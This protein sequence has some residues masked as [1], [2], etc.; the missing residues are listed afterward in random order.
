MRT[1]AEDQVPADRAAF[2]ELYPTAAQK[3]ILQIEKAY[4][5]QGICHIGGLVKLGKG[6]TEE[7]LREALEILMEE[8]PV[9]RLRLVSGTKLI[10][11]EPSVSLKYTEYLNEKAA[12]AWLRRP[13]GDGKAEGPPPLAEFLWNKDP[14]DMLYLWT[15]MHHVLLD[16]CG[17]ALCAQRLWSILTDVRSVKLRG[18]GSPALPE[19]NRPVQPDLRYL[20]MMRHASELSERGER[21]LKEQIPDTDPAEWQLHLP[22]YTDPQA[23]RVRKVLP[24]ELCRKLLAEQAQQNLSPEILI[25]AALSI[26]RTRITG[27]SAFAFGRSMMNRRKKEMDLPGMMANTLP[28]FLSAEDGDSF[29]DICRQLKSRFYSMMRWSDLD[30]EQFRERNGISGPWYDVMLTY[31]PWRLIPHLTEHTSGSRGIAEQKEILPAAMELPLR[32]FIDELEEETFADDGE[33]ALRHSGEKRSEKKTIRFRL[34]YQYQTC[35]Y[36]R[37]EIEA[38][39]LRLMTILEQG[40]LGR[41]AGEICILSE[42]DQK[43]WDRLNDTDEPL[44]G[45][46]VLQKIEEW[47]V[48][49]PDRTA[50]QRCRTAGPDD[51]ADRLTYSQLDHLAARLACAMADRGTGRGHTVGI[52]MEDPLLVPPACLGVWKTGASFLPV[53][54][55]ENAERVQKIQKDCDLFLTDRLFNEMTAGVSAEKTG[56]DAGAD[57]VPAG[58]FSLSDP[59]YQMYTSGSSGEAKL[60]VISH[61]SLACRLDWME[62]KYHC[63]DGVLQKAAVTFD[64]SVWEY[65]LPLMAGGCCYLLSEEEKRDPGIILQCM[66][67]YPVRTVHFVPSMLGIWLRYIQERKADLPRLQ[68]VFSSGEALSA[69]LA[70][71]V[72]RILPGVRLHNLYGPTECTIDVSWHECTK[73]EKE[74]PIGRPVSNTRLQILDAKKRLLPPGICGELSV[75]GALVGMG[76]RHG[77]GGYREEGGT[78]PGTGSEI[79]NRV[80]DTG[81]LAVLEPEG[82]ICYRGRKDSQKKVRGMRIDLQQIETIL[83]SRAGIIGAAADLDGSR[84]I[85]YYS[86]EKEDPGLER[87]LREFLPYYSVPSE[88]IFVRDI[89]TGPNGKLDRK[90]LR[91]LSA[92]RANGRMKE[93]PDSSLEGSAGTSRNKSWNKYQDKNRN[94][95]LSGNLDT[96]FETGLE[97]GAGYRAEQKFLKKVLLKIISRDLGAEISEKDN[98]FLAGADSLMTARWALELEKKG[99]T[100][101]VTDF[102]RNPTVQTLAKALKRLAGQEA[103]RSEDPGLLWLERRGTDRLVIAFPYAGG[104]GREYLRLAKRLGKQGVDVCLMKRAAQEPDLSRYR[105]IVLAGYCTG[106]VQAIR[107]GRHLERSGISPAGLV[108]CAAVPPSAFLRAAG[109]PWDRLSDHL[110][111]RIV[112]RL[113]GKGYIL[114]AEQ[115]KPFRKDAAEFFDFFKEEKAAGN[116]ARELPSWPVRILLGEK[117]PLTFPA[118]FMQRRWQRFSSLPVQPHILRG[119]GHFFLERRSGRIEKEI[120]SLLNRS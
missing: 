88:L 98:Y 120:M 23:D 117:D 76:Y 65:F 20:N 4:P 57:G 10:F 86:A 60:A 14:E 71:Q 56:W 7:M 51:K 36:K 50:C 52:R 100:A 106:T 25:A 42:E 109:S 54:I 84:I 32:I 33:P 1:A 46:S 115:V 113:H 30:L 38:L 49:A 6:Y 9:L 28:V 40:M 78:D 27:K 79:R 82:E 47:A 11:G 83:C 67:R 8:V 22:S 44:P 15:K 91:R 43:V 89:P 64:V 72:F 93:G 112:G 110:L 116:T 101:H 118:S 68:H 69:S 62:R 96:G 53:S 70:D 48:K 85:A 2:G 74:I 3:Q 58:S 55:R 102:Y 45:K 66:Q 24:D 37:K 94:K 26:Y 63:A 31:R 119:E 34:D 111:Q 77:A 18:A 59:A 87:Y 80:Y 29:R 16:S 81:D 103:D 21:W 108:L 41:K 61:R 97:N 92:G 35:C 13:F 39:H 104:S 5:G 99:Y 12:S 75:A 17:F 73:G 107:Q 114:P 105:Q 95:S 90:A 19:E